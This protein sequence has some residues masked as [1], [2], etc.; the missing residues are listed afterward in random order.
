MKKLTGIVISDK[1]V[2]SAVVLVE[3]SW[4]HPLYKKTIKRS[5]K[6]LVQNR[7]SAKNGD[8]VIIIESRPISRKIRF[9]ISE[10]IKK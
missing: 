5:K 3:S 1:M 4:S 8:K 2:G 9:I 6:F 10:I 7:L